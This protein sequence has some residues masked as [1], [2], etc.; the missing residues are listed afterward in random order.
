MK[1][2]DSGEALRLLRE[3]PFLKL[4]RMADEVRREKHPEGVVT[5]VV[6][7]NIN[8]S[9]V[10]VCQCKFCAFW[11]APGSVEGYLLTRE[12]IFR[13]I[14]E[15]VE[16]GG[17][18][19]LMQGGLH[20]DLAIEWFEELFSAISERFPA[21][22]IHSLSPAE[23]LHIAKISGITLE[24]CLGRLRASGLESIPG[25]G[26]EVL[27][28]SVREKISPNKIGWKDWARVMETAQTMG[29]GTT[30]TMM[31]G[32]SES[33]EDIV[34]HLLRLR[35]IQEKTGGFT[36]FI[37]WTFQPSHTEL[38]RETGQG[39][40][41]AVRYLRVL[42]LSRIVLYNFPNIQGSW[43]TQGEK[44][45]QVALSFGANDLGSTM[46]EENVVA[47]AGV[48]F[49]LDIKRLTAIIKDAG[50]RAAQR[51]TDYKIIKY[52]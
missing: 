36:A 35:E 6:D 26:A 22:R 45:A 31:F 48:R 42:A 18:Q 2:I 52:L 32:S 34:L 14:E 47:A 27:V 13:K 37:P 28:D 46:L 15:L 38:G 50:F 25:G 21:V 19:I 41:S 3:E 12:E 23:I 9:N 30:A 20:P 44:I 49:R 29:M 39:P 7:R 4:A 33:D 17:T 24:E 40:A 1:I 43:V 51:T 16:L 8:Y 5:F 10:C 11:R